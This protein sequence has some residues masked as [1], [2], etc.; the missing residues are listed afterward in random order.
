MEV[1]TD[2]N[3]M[4]PRLDDLWRMRDHLRDMLVRITGR[5]WTIQRDPQT[6]HWRAIGV[7]ILPYAPADEAIERWRKILRAGG[8]AD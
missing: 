1:P 4:P 5:D 8:R 3:G 2:A 7:M 6:G